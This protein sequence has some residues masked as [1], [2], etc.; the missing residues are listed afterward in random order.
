MLFNLF[1]EFRNI[2]PQNIFHQFHQTL[3]LYII[4]FLKDSSWISSFKIAFNEALIV[5]IL[6]KTKEYPITLPS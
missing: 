1:S 4:C 5:R 6:A 3:L 2:R